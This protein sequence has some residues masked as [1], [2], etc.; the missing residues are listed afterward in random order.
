MKHLNAFSWLIIL[1][2]FVASFLMEYFSN[3]RS[4]EGFIITLP[5][6]IA[7]VY[8]SENSA[9]LLKK[10]DFQLTRGEVFRRDLFLIFF[11]FIASGLLSLLF[12]YNNSDM[13]GWWPLFMYTTSVYGLIFTVIFS[14]SAL[15]VNNHK[16]YLIIFSFII[17]IIIL[18]SKFWP[19]YISVFFIGS[20]NTYL[21]IMCS[22][23]SFHLLVC[24][25]YKLINL[26]T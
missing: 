12:Q 7:T 24:S 20:I 18:F 2:F 22:L 26:K 6:I 25:A 15:I 10:T 23:I 19:Y 3:S 21:V 9:Y 4:L 8:W 17:S 14:Y 13:R 5:L 16:M 1:T 11:S